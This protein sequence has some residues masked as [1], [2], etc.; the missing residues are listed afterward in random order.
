M[1]EPASLR[2]YLEGVSIMARRTLFMIE[3]K[4]ILYQW[5]QGRSPRVFS[6]SR[7]TIRPSQTIGIVLN[8]QSLHRQEYGKNI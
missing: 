8:F 2:N 1:M 7:K 3:I 6:I 5:C 4:E